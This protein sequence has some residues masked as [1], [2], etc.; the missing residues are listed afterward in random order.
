[1][2]ILEF[3]YEHLFSTG[4][5]ENERI[6][7]HV[8]VDETENIFEVF[9]DGKATVFQLHEEGKLLEESKK[10]VEEVEKLESRKS[11]KSTSLMSYDD[12]GVN[13][14]EKVSQKTGRTYLLASEKNNANNPKYADLMKTVK[15][16]WG[17]KGN[18]YPYWIFTNGDAIGKNLKK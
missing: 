13:Y 16:R 1:M 12:A 8:S 10:V 3:T 4:K 14:E 15:D 5:F 11:G 17:K 18:T 6:G 7:I 2:K 9:K